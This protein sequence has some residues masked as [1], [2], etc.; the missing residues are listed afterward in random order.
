[1]RLSIYPYQNPYHT[2]VTLLVSLTS[3]LIWR[4][5]DWP[6]FSSFS[7]PNW[8]TI[9]IHA[10]TMYNSSNG[11]IPRSEGFDGKMSELNGGLCGS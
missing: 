2:F 5:D 4:A 10:K 9:T 6:V 7:I 8:N 3:C 11:K 1:M